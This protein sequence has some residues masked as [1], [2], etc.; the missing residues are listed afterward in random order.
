MQ[1]SAALDICESSTI[2]RDF[3]MNVRVKVDHLTRGPRLTFG[4]V[5]CLGSGFLPSMLAGDEPG[6]ADLGITVY[7][8]LRMLNL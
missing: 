8:L 1:N 4:V 5:A 3:N 7:W 2:Q 6:K